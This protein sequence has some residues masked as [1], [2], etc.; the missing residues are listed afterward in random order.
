MAAAAAGVEVDI[1][2]VELFLAELFVEEADRE[3]L[4]RSFM[5]PYTRE[6]QELRQI[7]SPQRETGCFDLGPYMEDEAYWG[8][9]MAGDDWVILFP[10]HIGYRPVADGI[11]WVTLF[12]RE[13][14]GVVQREDDRVVIDLTGEEEGDGSDLDDNPYK[15][16]RFEPSQI[17]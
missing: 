12:Q 5:Y 6:G 9:V 17:I 10:W 8:W 15:R 7:M 4:T 13:N 11:D 14:D 3:Y 2:L 1:P 16:R